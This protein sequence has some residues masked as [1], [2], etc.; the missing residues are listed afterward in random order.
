MLCHVL[1]PPEVASRIRSRAGMQPL[2]VYLWDN[3][4]RQAFFS[5]VY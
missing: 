5:H 1:I 3:I 4:L 2:D